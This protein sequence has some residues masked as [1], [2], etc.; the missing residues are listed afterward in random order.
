MKKTFQDIAQELQA[1]DTNPMFPVVY[2]LGTDLTVVLLV[3]LVDYQA[4]ARGIAVRSP[5]DVYNKYLGRKI[6]LSRAMYALYTGSTLKVRDYQGT[7]PRL[8]DTC[9]SLEFDNALGTLNPALTKYEVDLLQ[10]IR[11]GGKPKT[12]SAYKTIRCRRCGAELELISAWSNACE[13]GQEY[14]GFGNVLA[15]RS[16]WGEETGETESDFNGL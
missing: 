10:R 12:K 6:A 15:P 2:Y 13:C 11:E 4:L 16:Q 9:L 14:N 7:R 8:T 5:R 3:D 1:S